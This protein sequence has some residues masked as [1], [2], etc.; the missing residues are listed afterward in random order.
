L[1]GKLLALSS[2]QRALLSPGVLLTTEILQT[3]SGPVLVHLLNVDLAQPGIHLGI[4]QAQNRLI[5]SGETISNMANRSG[6]LAGINGDYFEVPGTG[7]P[8]GMELINGQLKQSPSMYA[9]LGV[10]TYGKFTIGHETFDASI[11]AG[12]ASFQLSSI[13]HL[14]E[15]N[16][17]K[18]GL[19][20][21][22][23]GAPISVRGDTVVLLE[24]DVNSSNKLIVLAIQRAGTMLPAL[25]NRYALVGR[26]PTGAWLR[27]H[28]L[29]GFRISRDGEHA[30]FVVFD[31]RY[32][33]QF[34]SKGVTSSQAAYFLLAHGA[35]QAMM[36][37]GGNSSEMVA[38]IS[39]YKGVS[40]VSYPSGGKEGR[41][42]NGLFVYA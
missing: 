33:S 8:I 16:E 30:L 13:N 38:R 23:L 28:L 40:V 41:L 27:A 12:H 21:P 42:A 17:G 22:A 19:I 25:V 36:F 31:G 18:L 3:P 35:Y 32:T 14:V 37:D 1:V 6:A 29:K 5:S 34:R 15:L 2:Q 4:V 9:V 10:T 26:G 7:R 24:R 39:G 20:T 11:T